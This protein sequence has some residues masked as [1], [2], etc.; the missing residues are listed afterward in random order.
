MPISYRHSSTE[1]RPQH[2]TQ[3]AGSLSPKPRAHTAILSV[4]YYTRFSKYLLVPSRDVSTVTKQQKYRYFDCDHIT[5][6]SD[7][8]ER[9]IESIIIDL[10]VV[11]ILVKE[12]CLHIYWESKLGEA[13]GTA[14]QVLDTHVEVSG[15]FI[16]RSWNSILL[17]LRLVMSAHYHGNGEPLKDLPPGT[18]T[19]PN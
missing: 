3:A 2:S 5:T 18:L 13:N 10:Q 16:R 4:A 14:S 1:Q 6:L 19:L 15:E 8:H 7:T 9:E 11:D 12:T 17:Q